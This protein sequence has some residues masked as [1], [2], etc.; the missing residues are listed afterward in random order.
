MQKPGATHVRRMVDQREERVLRR[1][2]A[3]Q[4][5][6][7]PHG[8]V[9]QIGDGSA[10]MSIVMRAHRTY[11]NKTIPAGERGRPTTRSA[12]SHLCSDHRLAVR[13]P[14]AGTESDSKNK[15]TH[16]FLSFV[17]TSNMIIL[18]GVFAGPTPTP[19]TAPPPFPLP[20]VDGVSL[21]PCDCDCDCEARADSAGAGGGTSASIPIATRYS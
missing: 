18:C 19:G 5:A 13:G 9:M 4:L 8:S 3:C 17:F 7:Q 15:N 11:I 2:H 21:P 16:A 6:T 20:A 12:R 10:T 14:N 1:L